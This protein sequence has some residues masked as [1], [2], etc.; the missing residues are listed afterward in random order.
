M[1]NCY[2]SVLLIEFDSTLKQ[3]NTASASFWRTR[4]LMETLKSS[5]AVRDVLASCFSDIQVKPT[6]VQNWICCLEKCGF[7]FHL[8]GYP[9][10][11]DNQYAVMNNYFGYHSQYND[12]CGKNQIF[13]CTK[14]TSSLFLGRAGNELKL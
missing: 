14:E 1:Q 6:C 11:Y 2:A 8:N 9:K 7:S 10:E 13:W 5:L 3:L 12:S 4:K